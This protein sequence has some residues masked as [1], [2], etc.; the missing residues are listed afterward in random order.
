MTEIKLNLRQNL[1]HLFLYL[2]GMILN[3]FIIPITFS[4][5]TL[6]LASFWFFFLSS[7]VNAY[8]FVIQ[9]VSIQTSFGQEY[10]SRKIFWF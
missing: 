4:L 6:S 10:N 8:F 5:A 1:F 2:S 7:L 9:I 3:R